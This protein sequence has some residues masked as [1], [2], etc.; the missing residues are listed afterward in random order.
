[1]VKITNRKKKPAV[2]KF[3]PGKHKTAVKKK[4]NPKKIRLPSLQKPKLKKKIPS[5][6]FVLD[7]GVTLGK[8]KA[9]KKPTVKKKPAT[10]LKA[11]KKRSEAAKKGWITRRKNA[12]KKTKK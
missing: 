5:K 4:T 8:T 12:K 11:I 3:H 9:K 2:K 7:G 10:K 1:M 6:A